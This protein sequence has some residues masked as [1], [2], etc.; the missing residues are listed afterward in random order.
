MVARSRVCVSLSS[1]GNS[2]MCGIQGE[3]V[4]GIR[5]LFSTGQCKSCT[6]AD[7]CPKPVPPSS[8]NARPKSCVKSFM[9][10]KPNFSHHPFG[11]KLPRKDRSN[12]DE[13]RL[14]AVSV[15]LVEE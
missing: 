15:K 11:S 7:P 9:G 5:Q 6:L 14:D 2:V 12:M 4:E 3:T 1:H 13:P 10:Q 8:R